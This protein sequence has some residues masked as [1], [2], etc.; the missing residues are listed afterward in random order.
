MFV[1]FVLGYSVLSKK[2][3][4][5]VI[6][7]NN[8]NQTSTTPSTNTTTQ[9]IVPNETSNWQTYR[10]DKYGF[11]FKYPQILRLNIQDVMGNGSI[12]SIIFKDLKGST[13]FALPQFTISKNI[14]TF[15]PIFNLTA[16][17]IKSCQ[18]YKKS[19]VNYSN[20]QT[21]EIKHQGCP[22][23]E[24]A[25]SNPLVF[26]SSIKTPLAGLGIFFFQT[27]EGKQNTESNQIL[28]TFK[29]TN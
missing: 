23:N 9:T 17:E 5:P 18:V 3:E 14:E 28:Q 11:E 1:V 8:Q 29:F 15:E 21:E 24:A 7:S 12:V 27:P 13:D 10:N 26:T 19:I 20:I 25:N 2:S 22:G 16:K 6:N 4:A